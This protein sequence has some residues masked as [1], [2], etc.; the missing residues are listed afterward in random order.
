MNFYLVVIP[1][2]LDQR[3]TSLEDHIKLVGMTCWKPQWKFKSAWPHGIGGACEC[4]DSSNKPVYEPTTLLLPS[5]VKP[6]VEERT[7]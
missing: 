2:E 7:V 6:S 4:P 1:P 5:P 3:W